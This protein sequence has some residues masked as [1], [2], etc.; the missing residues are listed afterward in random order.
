M[1]FGYWSDTITPESYRSHPVTPD[2][3]WDRLALGL[4]YVQWRGFAT[5]R[6][7]GEAV[8]SQCLTFDGVVTWPE[9]LAHYREH[10]LQLP[11]ELVEHLLGLPASVIALAA[12]HHKVLRGTYQPEALRIQPPGASCKHTVDDRGV[13]Q[14]VDGNRTTMGRCGAAIDQQIAAGRRVFQNTIRGLEAAGIEPW[15][16]LRWMART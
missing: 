5:C 16:E 4:T 11:V 15:R 13:L 14:C 6:V 9:G 12:E 3:A 2:E 8:G 10:G 7:C 1:Q